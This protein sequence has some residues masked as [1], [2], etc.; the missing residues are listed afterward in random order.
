M[1]LNNVYFDCIMVDSLFQNFI[2]ADSEL[3][4]HDIVNSNEL[5]ASLRFAFYISL[6]FE[7]SGDMYLK[8]N[9]NHFI[10]QRNRWGT[11]RVTVIFVKNG[12]VDPSSNP[13]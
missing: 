10:R 2:Q 3:F 5:E 13:G 8:Y 6:A 1:I 9:H 7:I 11:L 12:I 4:I